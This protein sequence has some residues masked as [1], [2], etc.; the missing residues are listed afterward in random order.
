MS[1]E[2]RLKGWRAHCAKPWGARGLTGTYRL[3]PGPVRCCL[4]G[5]GPQASVLVPGQT[6]CT[7]VVPEFWS[8]VPP[9]P[10]THLSGQLSGPPSR[11]STCLGLCQADRVFGEP[12]APLQRSSAFPSVTWSCT[13]LAGQGFPPRLHSWGAD[14]SRGALWRPTW[15][16][17]RLGQPPPPP[18]PPHLDSPS[19]LAAVRS[20]GR[21][22]PSPS[23]L[24]WPGRAPEALRGL[25][26]RRA[27]AGGGRGAG[28]P[29]PPSLS[30]S[31]KGSR[32]AAA[33]TGPA[34]FPGKPSGALKWGWGCPHTWPA[35]PGS[36][37]PP[38]QQA[39]DPGPGRPPWASAPQPARPR[40]PT[41]SPLLS[42]L[43]GLLHN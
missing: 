7:S 2:D 19:G 3:G 39:A 22:P 1:T 18:G 14:R 36:P 28:S 32:A 15:E 9:Q 4:A 30:D 29:V 24:G 11:P 13:A 35:H 16:T 23:Q 10:G 27:A 8:S 41:R 25:T 5:P 34:C 12:H 43:G 37:P 21:A 26:E 38:G 6:G 17:S 20:S 40:Q 31:Y 42:P 33:A